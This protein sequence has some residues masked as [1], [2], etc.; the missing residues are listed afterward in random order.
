[1]GTHLYQ[2]VSSPQFEEAD[3]IEDWCIDREDDGID[4]ATATAEIDYWLSTVTSGG[5][6]NREL[7]KDPQHRSG[8]RKA[9]RS[10]LQ[11]LRDAGQ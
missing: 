10:H 5:P 1:V 7:L 3:L 4:L 6:S 2:E 11:N 9:M 8:V